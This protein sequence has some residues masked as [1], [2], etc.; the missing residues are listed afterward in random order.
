MNRDQFNK[1]LED[2]NLSKKEFCEITDLKYP[3][4]NNWGTSSISVPKWVKS[5]LDNY[6]KAQLSEEI[7]NAIKPFIDNK[8]N[9]NK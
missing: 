4:V 3:T 1:L 7:I 2:A 5:W 6:I 8:I 9:E